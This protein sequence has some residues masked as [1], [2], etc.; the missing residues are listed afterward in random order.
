MTHLEVLKNISYLLMIKRTVM[1]LTKYKVE[2]Q[3]NKTIH[4]DWTLSIQLAEELHTRCS[5]QAPNMHLTNDIDK[6]ID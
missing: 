5:L 6:Q 2:W 4:S 3:L 1:E